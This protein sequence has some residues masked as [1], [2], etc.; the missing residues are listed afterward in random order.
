MNEIQSIWA[1]Q[2]FA[3]KLRPLLLSWV[4]A[5]PN[6]YL[7]SKVHCT[8]LGPTLFISPPSQAPTQ[9]HLGT[10]DKKEKYHHG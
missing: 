3:L 2:H 9:K 1:H 8:F 10:D 4:T 5:N 6:T 7:S